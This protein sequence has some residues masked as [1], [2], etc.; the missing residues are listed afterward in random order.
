MRRGSEAAYA[1]R[2]KRILLTGMSGTGKSTLI[3]ELRARGYRAVDADDG[4]SE[5]RPLDGGG[6]EWVWREDRVRDVLAADDA[7]VLF[8]SGC[9][10]N[11]G[12]FYPRFDAIVLLTAP[13]AVMLERV[14][15]R[16]TNA[17]GQRAEDVEEILENKRHIEPL[18]RRSA[19]LELDTRA[20][21]ADLVRALIALVET[22]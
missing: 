18:L 19:T 20:P 8:L 3:G 16:T 22:G 12:K 6:R 17:Y 9:A 5:Y 2:V 10:S 15:S 4:L 13:A 7:G 14:R 11:Q 21:V 1:A